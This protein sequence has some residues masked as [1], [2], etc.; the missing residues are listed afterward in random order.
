[1][2]SAEEIQCFIV[3]DT[4]VVYPPALSDFDL[5]SGI[6]FAVADTPALVAYSEMMHAVEQ[7]ALSRERALTSNLDTLGRSLLLLRRFIM[8][9]LIWASRKVQ[10]KFR[11]SSFL[12]RDLCAS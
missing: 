6:Q 1:M 9:Q 3:T 8:A 12:L 11:L 5:T 4:D 7:L 10:R 2:R